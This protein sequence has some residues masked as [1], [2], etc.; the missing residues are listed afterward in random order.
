MKKHVAITA[1]MFDTW[2]P[3]GVNHES[4]EHFKLLNNAN[5]KTIL[6]LNRNLTW[7]NSQMEWLCLLIYLTVTTM[8]Y[9]VGKQTG[10]KL[11]G[12]QMHTYV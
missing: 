11:T 8:I 4:W 5:M 9:E 6:L 2:S 3:L 12:N 1:V 10:W 7:P